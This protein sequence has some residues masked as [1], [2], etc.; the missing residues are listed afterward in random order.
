MFPADANGSRQRWV[1]AMTTPE[2]E[3]RALPHPT[4]MIHGREDKVIP[5]A[6]SLRLF[7]LI[8]RAELH[9]FGHCGHWSQIERSA[10]FNRIVG[11][12]LNDQN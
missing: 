7:E 5:L 9:A 2:D 8:E 6:T 12:F 11:D 4:A 10:Q 3:I 1:Q